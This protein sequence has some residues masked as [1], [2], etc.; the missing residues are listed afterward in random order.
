M[1]DLGDIEFEAIASGHKT[2]EGDGRTA[3][4]I[5]A[6]EEE[7]QDPTEETDGTSGRR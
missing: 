4:D 1:I 2:S 5:R 7:G 6:E 3:A